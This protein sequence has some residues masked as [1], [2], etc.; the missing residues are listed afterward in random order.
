[1]AYPAASSVCRVARSQEDALHLIS[2][3]GLGVSPDANYNLHAI[4]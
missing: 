3:E 1:V 4:D 2:V